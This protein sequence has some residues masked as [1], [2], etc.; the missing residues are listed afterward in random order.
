MQ[1]VRSNR[2]ALMTTPIERM[3][4]AECGFKAED[5]IKLRCPTCGDTK[6]VRRHKSDLPA[7]KTIVCQCRKCD[8][9]GAPKDPDVVYL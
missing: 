9:L 2:V 5:W 3:I 8:Q 1:V 6:P 4:D 7:A